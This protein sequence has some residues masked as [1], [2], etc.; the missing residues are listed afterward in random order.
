MY[1]FKVFASV[2]PNPTGEQPVSTFDQPIQSFVWDDF[3]AKEDRTYEYFFHPLKGE[4]K[5]IDRRA[6]AIPIL[7][8]TEPLF[9][10]KPHDVFFNRGVASSQAYARK[11]HNVSPDKL[12]PKEKSD[13]A[14]RWLGR[15]LDEAIIKFID[16][17]PKGDALL[18]C[19]YEFRYLPVALALKRATTRGVKVQIIVDAKENGTK[20]KK[21]FP[22]LDNLKTIRD[23][24]LPAASIIKRQANPAKIQHNKFMVR[25]KGNGAKA[26]LIEVWTGSTNIS[27]GGISA[28]PTSAIGCVTRIPPKCTKSTGKS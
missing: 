15:H 1:G 8:R 9:S 18:C 12:T 26:K 27:E 4:P 11:F 28:R 21:A 2:V 6:E 24:K 20:K 16:D 23:A 25:L 22:R 10:K 17:T 13:E 7:V 19:F 14:F 5:N 3:T